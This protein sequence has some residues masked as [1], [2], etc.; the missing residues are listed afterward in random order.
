MKAWDSSII[1][2]LNFNKKIY[3]IWYKCECSHEIFGEIWFVNLNLS[4]CCIF[5]DLM[6]CGPISR[7]WSF[8][9][10]STGCLRLIW[11]KRSTWC[12]WSLLNV[13]A[14]FR[15]A[16]HVVFFKLVE[17]LCL[18]WGSG[19]HDVFEVEV[20]EESLYLQW[21]SIFEGSWS[22]GRNLVSSMSFNHRGKLESWKK[23]CIFKR[24]SIFEDGQF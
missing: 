15:E 23:P 24:V 13:Y 19:A 2:M 6:W 3:N 11:R 9:S 17:C 16:R 21:A 12:S 1:I 20:L 5:V 7:I 4:W 18:I 8:D 10:L 14:W 22:V